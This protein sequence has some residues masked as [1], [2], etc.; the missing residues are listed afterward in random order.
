MTLIEL[1]LGVAIAGILMAFA[2]PAFENSTRNSRLRGT[3]MDLV[4]AINTAR[5]QAIN[6]R[7]D[8]IVRPLDNA[9][10]NS[11]IV[12]GFDAGIPEQDIEVQPRSGVQIQA[13]AA[14]TTFGGNGVA[15]NV[16]VFSICD[17]RA[18]E[19]GRQ[20]TVQRLGRVDTQELN[21]CF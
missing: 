5:A 17:D 11:G 10:W 12:V 19:T 8:V 20:V 4:S 1:M 15:S 6:Y 18:D 14:A 13:T 9:D 2:V 21:P 3:T 16:I 7:R